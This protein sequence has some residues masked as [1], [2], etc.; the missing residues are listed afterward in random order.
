MPTT[1]LINAT[2]NQTKG[3]IG[4]VYSRTIH[5]DTLGE[6]AVGETP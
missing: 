2:L 3:K 6:G 4:G 1:L 5:I